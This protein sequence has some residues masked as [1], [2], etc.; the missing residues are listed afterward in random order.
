MIFLYGC[1]SRDAL[2]V[3]LRA[4][5]SRFLSGSISLNGGGTHPLRASGGVAWYPDDTADLGT[6]IRYA[7]FAMYK[8]KNSLKGE[9][10]DFDAETY[11]Q[12]SY[13]MEGTHALS[14]MIDHAL[15][16]YHF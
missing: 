7:D 14:E 1:D 3:Y 4:L 15:V 10:G 5:H 11:R 2:R 9:F 6:L 13:L 8:V 12:E 16:D